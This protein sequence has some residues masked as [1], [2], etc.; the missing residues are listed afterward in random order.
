MPLRRYGG[1]FEAAD[2]A[3]LKRVF[4]QLCKE[5]F[6]AKKDV[7]QMEALAEEVVSVF[8]SGIMD[9][10]DLLQAL[11]KRRRRAS[12]ARLGRSNI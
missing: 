2:L 10:A 1:A 8:Q 7:A 12:Y 11:S 6:L 3:L 5:R 4:D 9:E